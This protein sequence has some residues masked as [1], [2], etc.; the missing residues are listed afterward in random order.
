MCSFEGIR[1]LELFP[2]DVGLCVSYFSE[3]EL[4]RGLLMTSTF[5]LVLLFSESGVP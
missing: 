4:K 3:Y 2:F 5:F 1:P